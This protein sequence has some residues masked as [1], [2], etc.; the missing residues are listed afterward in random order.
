[1]SGL[2]STN[3]G[4]LHKYESIPSIDTEV[5]GL[6]SDKSVILNPKVN[7]WKYL[8]IATTVSLLIVVLSYGW[9]GRLVIGARGIKAYMR[10]DHS[11]FLMC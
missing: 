8:V 6:V 7:Y 2:L 3:Q 1:M 11:H 5:V 9:L 10:H 4:L